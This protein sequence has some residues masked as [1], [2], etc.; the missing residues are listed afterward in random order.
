ML[1]NTSSSKNNLKIVLRTIKTVFIVLKCECERQYIDK[2]SKYK[3]CK[4]N[5]KLGLIVKLKTAKHICSENH[6]INW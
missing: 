6:K 2:T 3:N 5:M 4:N 1:G